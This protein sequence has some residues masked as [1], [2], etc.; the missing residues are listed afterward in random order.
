MNIRRMQLKSANGGNV[1]MLIWLGKQYLG[2]KDKQEIA[3]DG[4]NTLT[5]TKRI[6]TQHAKVGSNNG[7]GNGHAKGNGNGAAPGAGRLPQ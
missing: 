4:D 2:Q 7:N 5:I 6:V 1:A 3:S